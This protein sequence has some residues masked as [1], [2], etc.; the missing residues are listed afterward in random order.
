M[1]LCLLP[2]ESRCSLVCYIW[3]R[4]ISLY[5]F[6]PSNLTNALDTDSLWILLGVLCTASSPSVS[7]L[8]FSRLLLFSMLPLTRTFTV[9]LNGGGDDGP[10]LSL[11]G[12]VGRLLL[13]AFTHPSLLSHLF[14][15]LCRKARF[16]WEPD[17]LVLLASLSSSFPLSSCIWVSPPN[18]QVMNVFTEIPAAILHPLLLATYIWDSLHCVTPECFIK[19][20]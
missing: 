14:P 20:H 6:I 19:G 10:W 13:A 17:V 15:R 11:A 3:V 2:F 9:V 16:P 12:S 5:W 18:C 8:L 7:V 1:F 4:L